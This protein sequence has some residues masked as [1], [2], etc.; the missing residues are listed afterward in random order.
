M[1]A[2]K[3][4]IGQRNLGRA[5]TTDNLGWKVARKMGFAQTFRTDHMHV[6]N[7]DMKATQKELVKM[8]LY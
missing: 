8:R 7:M 1:T 6:I 5:T 2:V 4:K 3:E